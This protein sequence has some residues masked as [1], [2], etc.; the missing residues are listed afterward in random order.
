M[1]KIFYLFFFLWFL[2]FGHLFGQDLPLI[3]GNFQNQTIQSIIQKIEAST[4]I[5]FYYKEGELPT[6]RITASFEQTPIED[7]LNEIF[8]GTE[9]GFLIYR[10]YGIVIMPK[11]LTTASFTADYYEARAAVANRANEEEKP[12]EVGNVNL[13]AP[14]GMAKVT[15][16]VLDAEN[17]DPVIGATIYWQDLELGTTTDIDGKFEFEIPA[18]LHYITVTYIGFEAYN[19][20][21]QVESD[22]ELTIR[23]EYGAVNLEEVTVSAEAA[24][25]SVETVQIGKAQIDVES[26]KKTPALLG[27][28]DVVRSLLLSPGVSTVGEGAAGFNV[29]G[30]DVDQNLILQDEAML[31]NISHALGFFSSFNTDLLQSVELYKANMPAQYGGRLASV[32]DVQMRDGNFEQFKIKAGVGPITSKLSLEGPIAKEKVSF[33]AGFRSSYVDWILGLAENIEVQNSSAFFYDANLR[34]TSKLGEKNTLILS[35]YG[36]QD[37]FTYNNEFGFDYST[38]LG[39]ATLKS[40]FSD[41]WYSNFS[42]SYVQYE[43]A[44]LDFSSLSNSTLNNQVNYIKAKEVLTYSPTT[45]LKIDGGLSG[46][47]YDV[48]PGELE[49]L[50]D[51]SSVT[52]Q[53]VEDER[54]FEGAAFLNAEWKISEALLVSAGVRLSF[55]QFLGAQ[56]VYEY[57]N[58]D[59]LDFNEVTGITSYGSGEAIATYFNPEPRLSARY[60]LG[61]TSSI[62]AGYSRTVQYIN[63]IFNTDSPTP[64]SQWQLSTNYIEPNKSHNLSLGYFKNFNDNV[65]ELSGEVYGRYI[66]QLYDYRDFAELTVNDHLETELRFGEGRTYGFEF[67]L[68]KKEGPVN[69]TLSYTFSRSERQIDGINQ[70]DWYPSNFD[71]P[72][73][74]SF[75]LNYQPNR[76]NTLTVNFVFGTGRPATPPV[77]NYQATNG[78][79]IPVYALRNQSRIPDYHRMDVAYTIGKGYKRDKKFQTSWTISVYNVYGRKNAYSVFFTQAPFQGAQANKLALLGTVFPSLTFNVEIL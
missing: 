61:P 39:Q 45:L 66:D 11:L 20:A 4:S 51:D 29:R 35:G 78:L 49:P 44:R 58:P 32:M 54:G 28:A 43:S 77:G 69:G 19:K 1:N 14:S 48:T 67:S 40:I 9:M 30:G 46:I 71:K 76:R 33:I 59:Q 18:G 22:G 65:W 41:E 53:T 70:G 24:D 47:L 74:I 73:D 62:K 60:R 56:D 27:E 79:V 64:V 52:P 21:V 68:K 15:G 57:A 31:F 2:G 26:I 17:R 38:Y 3:T 25:A 34:V 7:A 8:S 63:Q 37:D 5:G 72:H 10:D 23:L 75:V 36:S 13:L 55:F 42:A 6:K 16:Q 50:G 12:I